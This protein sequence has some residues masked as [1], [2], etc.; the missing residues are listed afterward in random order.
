MISRYE[1][2]TETKDLCTSSLTNFFD[3]G[4]VVSCSTMVCIDS[5]MSSPVVCNVRGIEL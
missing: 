4:I 5:I 2:G 3:C 1:Y